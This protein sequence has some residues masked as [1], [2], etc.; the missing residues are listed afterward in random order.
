MRDFAARLIAHEAGPR[1]GGMGASTAFAVSERMRTHLTTLMGN[2]GH[3]ALLMRALALAG[4]EV[5]WLREVRVAV[6]GTLEEPAPSDGLVDPEVLRE[7]GVV[8]IAQLMGLLVAFI[9]ERLTL[10]L[11]REVWPKLPARDLN[12]KI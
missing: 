1:S 7:G 9:G 4:T 8:L 3:R 6:D 12:F 10:Q 5:S 2:G 11:V